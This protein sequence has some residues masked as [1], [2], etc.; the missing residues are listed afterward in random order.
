[1]L[2]P[3]N[4]EQTNVTVS[5]R[6]EIMSKGETATLPSGETMKKIVKHLVLNSRIRYY[7][8][9]GKFGEELKLAACAY[10]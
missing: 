3:P 1:M 6:L 5:P 9:A 2:G 8:L 7:H 4:D 10:N